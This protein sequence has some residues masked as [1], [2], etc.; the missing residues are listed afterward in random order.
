MSTLIVSL[1]AAVAYAATCIYLLNSIRQRTPFNK[2]LVA[3][4]TLLGLAAHGVSLSTQL[5]TEQ[6]LS[7]SLFNSA[8]L[9]AF[10]IIA[11]VLLCLTRMS[12]HILLLPLLSL[13]ALSVLCAQFIAQGHL[14]PINEAP[15]ILTHILLSLLAYS[16]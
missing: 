11:L 15:G 8:S 6:G 3:T 10:S 14:Q 2:A 16:M 4:L 13:G 12:V 9:I 1:L 7:L 5:I